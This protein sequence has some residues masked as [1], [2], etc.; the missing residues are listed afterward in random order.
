MSGVS[1][2]IFSFILTLIFRENTDLSLAE[3]KDI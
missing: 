3:M 2:V 1:A